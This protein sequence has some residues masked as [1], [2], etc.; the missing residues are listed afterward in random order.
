ME[1]DADIVHWTPS[2]SEEATVVMPDNEHIEGHVEP[3]NI[4][5]G[6]VVQFERFGFVRCDDAKE[7]VFYYAHS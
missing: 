4:G 5:E 2:N 6:E 7:K 1:K 3:A